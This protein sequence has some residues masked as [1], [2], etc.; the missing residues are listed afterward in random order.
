MGLE[1]SPRSDQNGSK[2]RRDYGIIAEF[3][4]KSEGHK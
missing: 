3:K 2:G 1:P 4:L